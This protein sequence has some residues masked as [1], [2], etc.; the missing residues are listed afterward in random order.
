MPSASWTVAATT[1]GG[2][3]MGLLAGVSLVIKTGYVVVASRSRE[4]WWGRVVPDEFGVAFGELDTGVAILSEGSCASDWRQGVV[5]AE[6]A[7]AGLGAC[8]T[9]GVHAL[10]DRYGA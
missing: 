4:W 6:P 10:S 7:E 5:W 3:L 2:A 1:V 9:T 8:H